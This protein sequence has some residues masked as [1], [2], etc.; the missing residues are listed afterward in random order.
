MR[1]Y[2]FQKLILNSH[3]GAFPKFRKE[4]SIWGKPEIPGWDLDLLLTWNK[5]HSHMR[6]GVRQIRIH[7]VE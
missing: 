7:D 3:G 5:N 6:S 4:K 1:Y 2:E